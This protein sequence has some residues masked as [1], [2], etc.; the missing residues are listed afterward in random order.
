MY[1]DCGTNQFAGIYRAMP[2]RKN[3]HFRSLG[4]VF[5]TYIDVVHFK[6]HD[7]AR[8]EIEDPTANEVTF[9]SSP[10]AS[11]NDALQESEYY[12]SFNEGDDTEQ[13]REDRHQRMKE[14]SERPDI[15][16]VE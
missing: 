10:Q 14:I 16:E 9:S 2:L 12:T 6:K 8:L 1:R 3:Q 15:Y 4:S 7:D 5:K 11:A 13:A